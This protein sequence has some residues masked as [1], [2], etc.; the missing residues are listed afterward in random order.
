MRIM[1]LINIYKEVD[2][3]ERL[4]FANQGTALREKILEKIAKQKETELVKLDFKNIEVSDVSFAREG[5]VKLVTHLGLE[6]N[7]PQVIFIN[8]DE[9]V[10]QN[11]NL[12]FKEHKKLVLITD[13][14]N[15]W[16][17]IGKYSQQ[18]VETIDALNEEKQA[19]AKELAQK[20]QIELTTCNNR[21]SNLYDMC[22]LTR[23]EIGQKSGGIEFVYK[24]GI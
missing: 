13:I 15:K 19:T 22:V 4:F 2:Q 9:Y 20:L 24:I 18:V 12:S 6:I 16:E 11:L 3:K 7:H 17:M 1:I 23:K 5:F 14:R 8:V 21:L 10:K